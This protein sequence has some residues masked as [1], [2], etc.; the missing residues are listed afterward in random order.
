RAT[1]LE[2][3]GGCYGVPECDYKRLLGLPLRAR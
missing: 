1:L 3:T 2:I